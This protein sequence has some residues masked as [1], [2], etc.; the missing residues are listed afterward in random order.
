MCIGMVGY[1][2]ALV[3]PYSL[4][5]LQPNANKPMPFRRKQPYPK[6]APAENRSINKNGAAFM[7][8]TDRCLGV[9]L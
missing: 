4:S 5:S 6:L 2:L 9:V 7:N 1:A 8:P 3:Y